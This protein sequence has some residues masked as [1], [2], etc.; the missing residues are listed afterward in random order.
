MGERIK[1][2]I[3]LD[4]S[5]I[6]TYAE[7]IVNSLMPVVYVVGGIGLGFVVVNKIISA[8]R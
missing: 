3:T 6:F 2:S 5:Q 8:L 4:V 7:N 1:M